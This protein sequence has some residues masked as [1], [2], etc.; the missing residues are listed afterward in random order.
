MIHFGK[1]HYKKNY[2]CAKLE[3]KLKEKFIF[4]IKKGYCIN[5]KI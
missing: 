2:C 1:H 5:Q 3:I 4:S